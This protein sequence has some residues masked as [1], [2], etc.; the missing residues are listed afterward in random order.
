[1]TF[2]GAINCFLIGFGVCLTEEISGLVLETCP[3]AHGR[4]GHRLEDGAVVTF[5][6]P[7]Q[8]KPAQNTRRG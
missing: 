3:K 4:R 2:K 1:M 5:R 7:A 6:I 8:K